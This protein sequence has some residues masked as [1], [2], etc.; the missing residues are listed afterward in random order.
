MPAKARFDA[1]LAFDSGNATALRGR[2]ELDLKTGNAPGAVKDAEK[3]VTVLPDSAPDRLLLARAYSAAGNLSWAERTLWAAFQ[4]I[5][6]D[7]SIYAALRSI[8]GGDAE[9]LGDLQ[10]EFVRQRTAK[11]TKGLL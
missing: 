3:L 4:D 7:E 2:A 5:P 9:Q 1:V 10:A 8:K 11:L 6:G